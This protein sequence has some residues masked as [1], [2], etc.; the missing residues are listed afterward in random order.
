ME[1]VISHVNMNNDLESKVINGWPQ[2]KK[3]FLKSIENKK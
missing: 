2:R 3:E 1:R